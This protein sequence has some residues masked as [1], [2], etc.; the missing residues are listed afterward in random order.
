MKKKKVK[1]KVLITLVLILI[2]LSLFIFSLIKIFN[3][4]K[5]NKENKEIKIMMEEYVTI[6]DDIKTPVENKYKVDFES[7]KKE[8]PD[9]VAYIKVNG[10]NIDYIVVKGKDNEYYLKHNFNKNYNV[11]GWIFADFHNKFD[12]SDKN[13]IIYGHNTQDGSMFGTL[14]NV[15]TS[16]WQNNIEN[17]EVVLV[18]E[19]GV[20]IYKVF[21]T[22]TIKPEEYYINTN[23]SES[24]FKNFVNTIYYRSNHN[25]GISAS[26]VSS[27]LTLSSCTIGGKSRVVLHAVKIKDE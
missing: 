2:F 24:E 5:D 7:L 25:Y 12:G 17:G 9:T 1:K 10:T 3:Y 19:S 23:F 22:Y 15:L 6:I 18:T 8:N 16:D 20:E 27:V 14:K 21:S 26:N 4:L 11:S 13:I